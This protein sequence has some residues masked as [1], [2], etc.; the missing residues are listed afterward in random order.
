MPILVWSRQCMNGDYLNF[1]RL[2]KFGNIVVVRIDRSLVMNPS[3]CDYLSVEF[4]LGTS[5]G[6]TG[7]QITGSEGIAGHGGEFHG[8]TNVERNNLNTLDTI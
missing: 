7:T 6:G 8:G 5:C 4:E 3:D 2:G 1:K